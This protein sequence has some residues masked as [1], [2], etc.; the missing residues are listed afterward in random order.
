V[1]RVAAVILL[2][3]SGACT[4]EAP[5]FSLE[6]ARAH[7]QML[8]GTI[9]SRAIGTP[10]NARARQ[11]I[12]DQLKLYGYET[13]VQET[14]AQRP[15]LGVTAHVFNII[16]TKAGPDRGALGL[17][18]HYDSVP[19]GPGA[20]DDAQ[21]V[22]V[23]LEAARVLGAREGRRHTVMVLVTD[24]EEAGLMGAAGLTTDR[25]VM[26]RLKAYINLE[27]T[28][29]AGPAI[30]FETGPGNGWIVGPW[31]RSAPHPRGA[32]YT[33]EIYRRLPNDTDFS[34][35][36][37]YDIP[38]LNFALVADSYPYHTARDT[39]DRVPD[40]SLR[41]T[42]ENIVQ[43][44]IALDS[45]DLTARTSKNQTFF[46]AGEIIAFSWGPVTAWILAALALAA[47]VLASFKVIAETIR[48]VGR[49]R[50]MLFVVWTIVGV[51][52]VAEV[53][54]GGTWALREARNVYHP[55]YAYPQRLFLMLLALGV[56]AGW[57]VARAGAL[58][59]DRARGPRHPILAWSIA[60]PI[61]I[62]LAGVTG[63]LAP[64]AA[65]L[66]TLPL[67]IAGAGLL[68]I[69][70]T[71][72]PAVRALSVLVLAV[73]GT[74]WLHDVS[75]LLPFL[76]AL[77]GRL[78]LITPVWIFA[79]VML[80][81]GV[82]VVPPLLAAVATERPIVG[83]SIATAVLLVACVVTTGFAYAAP[84]YTYAQP[85]RRSMRVLNEAGATNATYE[86]SSQEPG[87]DLEIGAPANWSRVTDAPAFSLP[88]GAMRWPFVFRTTA[89]SPGPPPASMTALT[90]TP[91]AGATDLTMTIVPQ[92]PG[93]T[94]TFVL[95]PGVLP[96]RSNFPG[97]VTH[98]R[99]RAAY[100]GVPS[101]GVTWLASF[102]TSVDSKLPSATAAILSARFPNGTGPQSLP[103]WLPQEHAVWN[104]DLVWALAPPGGIPPVA[105]IK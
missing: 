78:P 37:R 70:V 7:L 23:M 13:R 65:Y 18:S 41:M 33:Y 19:E 52:I 9:G 62:L 86:I 44:A 97:V 92:S 80:A 39:A 50:W 59:P 2:I 40:D 43:T 3:C 61:W 6:N 34:I 76:V 60:L 53:M 69:P 22:G 93:L 91:A 75:Q 83:P 72:A 51:A 25:D 21:G 82:M 8:A 58:L 95:P 31:A 4:R 99:W 16:A 94:A 36:K 85:Q 54:I 26:D 46:D 57:A 42:G 96:I 100:I 89:A 35:L 67:L 49:G 104:L 101:A 102:K 5:R 105:P 27:A 38:G 77:L 17:V 55:W 98:G 11:Y 71:S 1:R 56:T 28:G 103:A 87:I 15:D 30:L 45:R 81:C 47:G 48:L 66:W 12:V 24:G 14:D 79:A 20:G 68:A 64:A 90:L 88:I 10:E 63:A 32:S 73:T 84:A 29:A 74:L